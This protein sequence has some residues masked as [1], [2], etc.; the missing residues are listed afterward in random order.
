M[1]R[2]PPWFLSELPDGGPTCPR[3]EAVLSLAAAHKGTDPARPMR[4]AVLCVLVA[5]AF[6]TALVLNTD[7]V[8]TLA[9]DCV[10]GRCGRVAQVSI[11]AGTA[12]VAAA[13]AAG[14][15]GRVPIK[16]R[17]KPVMRVKSAT[18]PARRPRGSADATPRKRRSPSGRATTQRK[19]PR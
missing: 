12:L 1:D 7:A 8:V 15:F 5:L 14:W 9:G 4:I 18:Q 6:A 19:K 10:L 17:L 11:L 2:L 3:R 16:P 13:F